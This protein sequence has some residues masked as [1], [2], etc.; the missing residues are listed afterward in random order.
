VGGWWVGGG[1]GGGGYLA[2]AKSWRDMIV[3][4]FV[5]INVCIRPSEVSEGSCL[6]KNYVI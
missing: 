6:L 1:G 4:F 2:F 5:I 3:F